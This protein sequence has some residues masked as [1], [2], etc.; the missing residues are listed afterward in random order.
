MDIN[1]PEFLARVRA[2]LRIVR[3]R[4]A[5]DPRWLG[6]RVEPNTLFAGEFMVND[7]SEFA[8]GT[9]PRAY[10][11]WKRKINRMFD[12]KD[13]DDEKQIIYVILRFSNNIYKKEKKTLERERLMAA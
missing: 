9:D 1:D 3:E 13:L 12:F 5:H 2:A 8:D 6:E 7:L 4:D 11:E 10:K